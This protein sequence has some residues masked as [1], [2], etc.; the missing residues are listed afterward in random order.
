MVI[1]QS[2]LKMF[3]IARHARPKIQCITMKW[4]T[5]SMLN[6]QRGRLI[7]NTGAFGFKMVKITKIFRSIFGLDKNHPSGIVLEFV[8]P[9]K[10]KNVSSRAVQIIITVHLLKRL[11]TLLFY[12]LF[13]N[14]PPPPPH[15]FVA[16]HF[17][18][19]TLILPYHDNYIL[20]ISITI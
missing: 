15:Q 10:K 19:I 16:L 4:G 5:K 6:M 2:L 17:S 9:L 18:L 8:D 12:T 20:P 7:N 13:L 14:L 11:L 3:T 1:L